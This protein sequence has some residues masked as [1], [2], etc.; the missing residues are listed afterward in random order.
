[1]R[2]WECDEHRAH[3]YKH[4]CTLNKEV[5]VDPTWVETEALEPMILNVMVEG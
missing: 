3:F 2:D 5:L 4:K 1:M